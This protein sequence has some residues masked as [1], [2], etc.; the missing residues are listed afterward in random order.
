[1]LPT[2]P[3][4]PP[5][6]PW[7][8]L[9]GRG[10]WTPG[11]QKERWRGRATPRAPQIPPPSPW[12]QKKRPICCELS[13][14][15]E[16]QGLLLKKWHLSFTRTLKITQLNGN[17]LHMGEI[18]IHIKCLKMLD[19]FRGVFTVTVN[20]PSYPP[21]TRWR[22]RVQCRVFPKQELCSFWLHLSFKG[23]IPVF[24]FKF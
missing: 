15:Q 17:Q 4:S 22:W 21:V 9:R 7:V 19:L 23:Q 3:R 14:N 13:V 10:V 24:N 12:L 6:S 5:A 1:M 20:V 8:W 18:F 2:S 16:L 11:R